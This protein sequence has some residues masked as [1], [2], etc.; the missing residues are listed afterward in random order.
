[1]KKIT[2]LAF[3]IISLLSS[4]CLEEVKEK[5]SEAKDGVSNA[6]T[7]IEEAQN[8]EERMEKL[9]NETA[10]TNDQLKDWLPKEIGGLERSGFK[11]GQ[12]GFAGVNS[13]EGTFKATEGTKKLKIAVV[14]GAGP[15]GGV[16]AAGY[17]MFGNLEMETEDEHKHQQTVT[18]DGMKAQQTYFKKKNNTQLLFM[19]GERFLV[20]MN[21]T[22]M[23][24]EETWE[25]VEKLDLEE[26]VDLTE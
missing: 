13:V 15:T 3:A 24:V 9:K 5:F 23:N 14:D 25:M 12:G 19:Y 11:V 2:N 10:L 8:V 7:I 18:V 1:M 6:T 16:M 26:L 17:G 4:S 22:D 20:T 21:S